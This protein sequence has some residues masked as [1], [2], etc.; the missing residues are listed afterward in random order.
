[1][2]GSMESPMY[3]LLIPYRLSPDLSVARP[4]YPKPTE[5]WVGVREC[6][7]NRVVQHRLLDNWCKVHAHSLA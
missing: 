1:M 3:A 4:Q 6:T 2:W 5:V 7:R